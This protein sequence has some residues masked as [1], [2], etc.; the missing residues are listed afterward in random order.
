MNSGIYG[1]IVFLHVISAVLAIGPLFILMPVIKRLRGVETA[2]EE[3]YLTVVNVIIRL[4]MH[5][6]HVLVY[7][8]V[9]LLIFG[10]WPWHTSWVI[11]TLAVML[12]SGVFLAKG[13]TV[14]LRRFKN[15][16]ANKNKILDRF[17]TTSLIYI[18]LM[19]IMLWLMVQKPMLW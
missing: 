3:V 17:N 8:G 1:A 14:V 12:L 9:L 13:F 18:G 7:T 4:V 16:N 19:L 5:A 6:G 15:P 2:S 10:P 11:M